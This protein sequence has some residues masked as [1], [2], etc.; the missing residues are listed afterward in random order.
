MDLTILKNR[1]TN[2]L[3][4][5]NLLTVV[6]LNDYRTGMALDIPAAS[7][8]EGPSQVP[9]ARMPMPPGMRLRV[10]NGSKVRHPR[11]CSAQPGISQVIHLAGIKPAAS[12]Q[13]AKASQF[14]SPRLPSSLIRRDC[15]SPTESSDTTE[16][17]T[18]TT[19]VVSRF[20]NLALATGK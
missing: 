18:P 16:R 9:P 19:V 13:L 8:D 20:V 12:W 10:V 6:A 5:T 2:L 11:L 7:Q 15:Q 1:N 14:T 4:S 3:S 17:K